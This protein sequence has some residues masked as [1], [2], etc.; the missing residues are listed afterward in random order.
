MRL[1]KTAAVL[2][3]LTLAAGCAD[4]RTVR[5][6]AELELLKAQLQATSASL[7]QTQ[8]NNAGAFNTLPDDPAKPA[9]TCSCG[10]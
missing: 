7:G 5:L 6:E 10:R 1:T 8:R 9:E 3:L 4:E 2:L